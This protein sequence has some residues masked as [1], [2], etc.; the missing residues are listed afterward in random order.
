MGWSGAA[1]RDRREPHRDVARRGACGSHCIGNAARMAFVR[2]YE[3]TVYDNNRWAGFEL[4]PGD[5]IISLTA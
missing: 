1:D 4:R 5:I 3:G 2:R